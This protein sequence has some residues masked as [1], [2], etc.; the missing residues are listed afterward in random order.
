[1]S[2]EVSG[3]GSVAVETEGMLTARRELLEI[4][5]RVDG[6]HEQVR[7]AVHYAIA[8]VSGAVWLLARAERELTDALREAESLAWEVE[9]AAE[10]YGWAERVALAQQELFARL[11][12]PAPEV[13]DVVVAL[14]INAAQ[15]GATS[16]S[17]PRLVAALR[18]LA[19]SVSLPALILLV[20]ALPGDALDETPV[21]AAQVPA[22]AQHT[23]A[24]PGGFADLAKR[25]P[26]A[27]PGRPQVRVEKYVLPDGDR[28]WVVYSAGTIDWSLSP[29]AEPWDDTSN[30]VGVAG[31]SAGSTRAAMLALAQAGWK[32]GEPVVPVGHSQ[33]GIVATA[34]ATS[35]V[36][37]APML[38][39]FGSPTA[40]VRT[41]ADTVDVA[42][43]HTDDPVPSL[44]GSPR[45]VADARL[46]V[47]EAAPGVSPGAAGV[48]AHAMSGYVQTA[49]EMDA[50]TD[51]RLVSARA[52]LADFT[53]G[54]TAEVTLWRGERVSGSPSAA[55]AAGR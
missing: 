41:P 50:S 9:A 52:S 36:A 28:H 18:G 24:P 10:A 1:M 8:A 39:T 55:S 19:D 54:Q 38:V 7:E 35:G 22:S 33:G 16:F 6:I 31:G 30:V 37:P 3:G 15:H 11:A 29:G 2:I 53:G 43:E 4:V 34:I 44:G 42:V 26:E 51:P 13:A 21:V 23:A 17:D 20:R 14:A 32:P 25:V 49:A 5:Q 47:T 27:Q 48:P 12:G 46:L 45:P 40:G